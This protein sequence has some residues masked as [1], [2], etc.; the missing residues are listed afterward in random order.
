[1]DIFAVKNPG[2]MTTIQDLGRFTFLDRGVP[3][4]G[5]LDS[6]S[7]RVA[8]ILVGNPENMAVLEITVMG[9]VLEAMEEADIAITGAEMGVTINK[10]PL[11]A[12]RTARVK[13][14]DILRIPRAETGCRAYLAVS[15]GFDVPYV[16]GSRSTFVRG[17]FGGLQG[18]GLIKG[19]LLKKGE[20]ALQNRLR[21]LPDEFIPEYRKEIVLKAIPGPQDNSF[22]GA[23]D[24]FFTVSYEVAAKS[25]RMGCRLQ[26]PFIGHDL[27]APQSIIT[28]PVMPG[29]IQI[30]A[31]GQ[32][33]LLLVE[34]TTG[35]Y[36]KIATVITTDIGKVAQAIPGSKVKFER[37]SV[38]EAHR[39]Y[40]EQEN[41][42]QKIRAVLC[43]NCP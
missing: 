13:K 42:L 27:D 24:S 34:Q 40:R 9:P 43:N 12:W 31:D 6:F 22:R 16:M 38:E 30:P 39:L 20:G 33:I 17:H 35:G 18:R 23:L 4:S 36:S 29:N 10:N 14:G 19:D 5:A 11:S 1:M 8:N 25:D 26:G 32:P 28:E 7:C 15:G 37:A 3:S 21:I 41:R 2:P